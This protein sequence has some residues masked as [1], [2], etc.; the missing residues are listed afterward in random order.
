[1]IFV[2]TLTYRVPMDQVEA[3]TADHRAYVKT[4][5]EQ[6][7]LLASGPF[8]PRV[9]GMLMLQAGSR[10]E[11]DMMLVDDPFLDRGIATYEVRQWIPT[12]GQ[13]ALEAMGAARPGTK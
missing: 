13:D 10:D 2:A 5:H 1:M 9:G 12:I 7:K 8:A 3:A 4:L 11:V 6:G